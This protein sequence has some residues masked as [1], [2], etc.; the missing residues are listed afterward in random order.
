MPRSPEQ[1][2]S[3][4]IEEAESEALKMQ[5]K[6]KSGKAENYNKAEEAVDE[7]RMLENKIKEMWEKE[8]AQAENNEV[9][10]S[11]ARDYE[12]AGNTSKVMEMWKK[13]IER[14]ES[15]KDW[16]EPKPIA[17]IRVGD[18][19]HASGD[20][21]IAKEMWNKAAKLMEEKR[22]YVG[23]AETYEKMGN[24]IES[25]EVWKRAAKSA[26]N[27]Q[28]Y[29]IAGEYYEK[30]KNESKAKEMW[31]KEAEKREKRIKSPSHVSI[32][33]RMI[34]A[35]EAYEKAGDIPNAFELW[36]KV[37]K[38]YGK[39]YGGKHKLAS[40]ACEKLSEFY[41]EWGEEM[42]HLAEM[43]EFENQ[44]EWARRYNKSAEARIRSGD[45]FNAARDYEEM[46]NMTGAIEMYEKSAKQI[47]HQNPNDVSYGHYSAIATCCEK[48]LE[49]KRK[50]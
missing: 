26:E 8:A 6:I 19:L 33:Q 14:G 37:A 39:E 44:R 9:Y 30:A 2:K 28:S 36:E 50:A 18:E 46:G 7:E 5:E 23:A 31:G 35:A 10:S 34:D 21:S 40:L 47:E 1:F 15:K 17:Y 25:R 22:D 42:K 49:L 43:D 16:Y 48:I 20:E 29:N 3:Y 32:P 11:A 12:K 41:K 27:M 24:R 45:Y 4:T 38:E 13:D